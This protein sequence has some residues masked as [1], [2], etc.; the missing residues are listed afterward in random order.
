M[1]RW[2]ETVESPPKNIF[3][4]II[5]ISLRVIFFHTGRYAIIYIDSNAHLPLSQTHCVTG[6]VSAIKF[7]IWIITGHQQ[8]QQITNKQ[9]KKKRKKKESPAQTTR[10]L[11]T[12]YIFLVV[13]LIF[14]MHKFSNPLIFKFQ[15][16]KLKVTCEN[17]LIKTLS[18]Y[19]VM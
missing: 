13:Y 17:K 4:K 6:R 18:N 8:Q 5:S 15:L 3:F 2:E 7:G 11:K 12:S 1:Y 10:Q 19:Q 9:T 16:G 14:L